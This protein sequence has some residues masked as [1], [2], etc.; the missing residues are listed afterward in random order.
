MNTHIDTVSRLAVFALSFL[1]WNAAF[2]QEPFQG[3][4]HH[5]WPV[6]LETTT[7]TGTVIVDASFPHPMYYLDEDGDTV[8]DYH[9]AFGP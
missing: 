7:V 2:A 8:A 3:G 6:S 1:L 4:P 9:L 5:S